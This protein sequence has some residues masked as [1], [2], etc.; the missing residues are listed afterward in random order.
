MATQPLTL[1]VFTPAGLAQRTDVDRLLTKVRSSLKPSMQ[2]MHVCET[3]HPEVVQSFGVSTLPAFV[4]LHRGLE[5]WRYSGPVDHL[6]L[7]YQLA[8]P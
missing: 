1:L 8:Q 3:V 2:I 5:L 7:L 4:L 6:D